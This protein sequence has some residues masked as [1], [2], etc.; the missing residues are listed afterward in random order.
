MKEQIDANRNGKSANNR[1]FAMLG[2]GNLA[3]MLWKSDDRAARDALRFNIFRVTEENGR[4]SQSF[5]LQNVEDL[6]RLAQVLAY[7]LS[8]EEWLD[9]ESRD[10]LSCLCACLGDVLG[11][12]TKATVSPVAPTSAIAEAL[13]AAIGRLWETEAASFGEEPSSKHLYRQLVLVD[14][15]LAGVVAHHSAGLPDL[16]PSA[17]D[18]LGDCPLCG[19]NDGYLNVYRHHWFICHAH[20]TRWLAGENLFSSWHTESPA[21]WKTNGDRIRPYLVVEPL[22]PPAD[23]SVS[24][25]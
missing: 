5:G 1:P 12:D 7:S 6:A 10:D 17:A 25:S 8:E 13:R 16:N 19:R 11:R 4:V 18:C 15:W 20:R 14:R 23:L 21:E 3:S 24:T 2:A 9:P 22:R